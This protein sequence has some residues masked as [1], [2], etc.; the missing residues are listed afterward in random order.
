MEGRECSVFHV[1][2]VVGIFILILLHILNSCTANFRGAIPMDI[3]EQ[4]GLQCHVRSW[5]GAAHTCMHGHMRR[6][7][8]R[9]CGRYDAGRR[10]LA[11]NSGRV[12][13]VGNLVLRHVLCGHAEPDPQLRGDVRGV[14]W[15]RHQQ[16]HYAV[17]RAWYSRARGGYIISW[18]CDWKA[19]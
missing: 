19:F 13:G 5:H 11:G 18:C 2:F 17:L 14:P 12:D 4:L 15:Q 10:V 7:H 8:R 3:V 9:V 1:V 6:W 16:L